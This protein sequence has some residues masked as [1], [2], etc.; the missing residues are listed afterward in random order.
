MGVM[1]RRPRHFCQ[2]EL[3]ASDDDDV[4][5]LIFANTLKVIFIPINDKSLFENVYK[6]VNRFGV[7]PAVMPASAGQLRS[8]ARLC[9]VYLH[10]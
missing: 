4:Y 10:Q 5:F 6:P 8:R 2:N 9:N 7:D 3:Q 1:F